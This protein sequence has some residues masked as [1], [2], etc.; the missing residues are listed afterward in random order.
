MKV[1]GSYTVPAPRDLVWQKLMDPK[2]LA[3]TLPGCE[4]FVPDPAGGFKVSLK[5]GVAAIKGSYEG[6][7]QITDVR[8]P[9]GYRMKLEGKGTGGFLKG[10][11]ALSLAES[12]GETIITY[13]GDAHLGGP[14]AALA[15]RLAQVAA[16]QIVNQFFQSFAG[17]V[18][19][20]PSQDAEK[21][22]KSSP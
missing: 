17:Q 3:R 20:V 21:P 2:V 12:S 14:I 18:Q 13:S 1:E 22:P 6:H 15:Q 4:K 8:P 11:G 5:I 16:R 10:N 7:V 9:E 19:N